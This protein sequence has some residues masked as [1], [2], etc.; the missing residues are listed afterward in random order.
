M[1]ASLIAALQ[2]EELRLV[3]E[4][5]ATMT[6]RRL[7]AI[8]RLIALYGGAE[9]TSAGPPT[10]AGMGAAGL[11]RGKVNADDVP[12]LGED[13]DDPG[14]RAVREGNKA[15]SVVRAALASVTG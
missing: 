3:T 10:S 12:S 4:L 8:R 2:S 14:S 13:P 1:H 6:F 5:R 11:P 9:G 7:D 15:V